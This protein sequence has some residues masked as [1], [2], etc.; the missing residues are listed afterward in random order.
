MLIR[1]RSVS[2][3]FKCPRCGSDLPEFESWDGK[4]Y[5]FVCF[6]C[7]AMTVLN[8]DPSDQE[9]YEQTDS[10]EGSRA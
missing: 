8:Y 9:K 10:S 3:A 1:I 6:D 7:H 5:T 2:M 4:H